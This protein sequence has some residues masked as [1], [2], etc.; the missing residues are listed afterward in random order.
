MRARTR[1]SERS[2]IPGSR[3]RVRTSSAASMRKPSSAMRRAPAGSLRKPRNESH[4]AAIRQATASPS[5]Q[6]GKVE[7]EVTRQAL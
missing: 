4:T 2:S 5:T 7:S 6:P 1:L 3:S